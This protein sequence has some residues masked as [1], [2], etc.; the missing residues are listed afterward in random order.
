MRETSTSHHVEAPPIPISPTRTESGLGI[1]RTGSSGRSPPPARR[2]TV[3][4]FSFTLRPISSARSHVFCRHLR[5][6]NCYAT[7]PID[8][9]FK[10]K[11]VE[12]VIHCSS[13]RNFGHA[14]RSTNSSQ[15]P[16]EKCPNTIRPVKLFLGTCVSMNLRH[17]RVIRSS[18]DLEEIIKASGADP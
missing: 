9:E 4:L 16:S 6:S 18:S 12:L 8:E 14:S 7:R 3:L 11:T 1:H 13:V 5:T 2:A 15:H 10:R 17:W